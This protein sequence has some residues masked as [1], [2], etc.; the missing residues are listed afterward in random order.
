MTRPASCSPPIRAASVSRVSSATVASLSTVIAAAAR[1][2]CTASN[3]LCPSARPWMVPAASASPAPLTL[4]TAAGSGAKAAHLPAARCSERPGRVADHHISQGRSSRVDAPARANDSCL[5]TMSA[6]QRRRLGAVGEEQ[7]PS[8]RGRRR[9]GAP[10]P[11]IRRAL[12][13]PGFAARASPA[14]KASVVAGRL[15]SITQK[16][17]A[18]AVRQG[19]AFPASSRR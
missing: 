15:A 11:A 4:R 7:G 5:A 1:P 9:G 17:P 18:S 10:S 13:A 16:S 3:R 12:Q 14:R 2:S 19:R 8:A 6:E